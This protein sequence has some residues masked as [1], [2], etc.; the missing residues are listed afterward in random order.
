MIK[1][2]EIGLIGAVYN[3]ASG[4]VEFDRNYTYI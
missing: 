2:K 1:K 3:L 4:E